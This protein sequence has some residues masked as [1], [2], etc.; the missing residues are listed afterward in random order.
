MLGISPDLVI[1]GGGCPVAG[2]VGY[3]AT[4]DHSP[5]FVLEMWV[6][7]GYNG[8]CGTPTDVSDRGSLTGVLSLSVRTTR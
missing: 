2:N 7:V 3:H 8:A 4:Y 1:G 6:T 5:W